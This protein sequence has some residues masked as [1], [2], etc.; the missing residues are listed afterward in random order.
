MLLPSNRF[1]LRERIEG[2]LAGGFLL[3][4]YSKR[5]GNKGWRGVVGWRGLARA[6]SSL[7]QN[8][9]RAVKI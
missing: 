7:L 6:A 2:I 9:P 5:K 3:E 1:E 4:V 8:C